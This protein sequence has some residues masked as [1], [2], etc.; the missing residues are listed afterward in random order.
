MLNALNQAERCL[1][2]A[3]GRRLASQP[4]CKSLFPDGRALHHAG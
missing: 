4:K 2:L 3:V 1:N